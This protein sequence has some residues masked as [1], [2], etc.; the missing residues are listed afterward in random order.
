[1]LAS[2]VYIFLVEGWGLQECFTQMGLCCHDPVTLKANS[3]K[4]DKDPL[5]GL[6][7][8]LIAHSSRELLSC[9]HH[10]KAV[11]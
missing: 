3:K 6:R 2:L 4:H 11:L 8:Y 5:T 7:M 1:M 9:H 10:C